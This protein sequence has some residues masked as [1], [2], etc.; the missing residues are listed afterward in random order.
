MINHTAFRSRAISGKLLASRPSNPVGNQNR[1]SKIEIVP[2]WSPPKF[3][4]TYQ[5]ACSSLQTLTVCAELADTLSVRTANGLPFL[6]PIKPVRRQISFER[7]A[8]RQF[9]LF[10]ASVLIALLSACGASNNMPG[11]TN[12]GQPPPTDTVS[13]KVQLNGAPLA[14]V[15]VTE[16][17]TNNNTVVATTTTDS[18]G[19]Y[20]FSGLST[21]GNSPALYQFWATKSGY[22]FYPSV[23]SGAEVV[24]FDH[25][26]NMQGSTSFGI[27]IFFTVI[28]FTSLPNASLSGAD[29]NAYDGGNP[30]VTLPRTGQTTSYA[31]GDDAA[32]Q[33]G[34]AWPAQRFTDNHDGT[35]TDGLTGLVWLKNA[36]CFTPTVWSNAITQVNQL[37]GGACGLTDQS[38]AGQW[39]M[40]NI[41]ELESIVDVSASNPALTPGSPFTNVSNAIYWSSTTYFGGEEG[42]PD[43]WT[44][45]FS[46]G[47]YMNDDVVNQKATSNNAVWAVKG[48]GGGTIK[49]QSTGAYVPFATG[50]DG[51]IQ[52]GVPPTFQRWADNDDG[53]VTD[54]VTGLIWLKQA[55]CINQP[56]SAAIAAVNSLASG[57]CG[58]TDG[59]AAGSWRMPNRNEMQSL[60]DRAENNLGAFFDQNYFNLDG[61]LFQAPIF[62]SFAENQ[63]YWTSSTDAADPSEAWTVFSCDFGV[64]DIPK[65]DSAYTLA[66]R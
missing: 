7:N 35:V 52:A 20:S 23:G 51:A 66:V 58:L 8:M 21:S 27:A 40:P 65:F 19:A 11:L 61:T 34:A 63:Y 18:N 25:T 45:R 54:T 62:T 64:Y 37:A 59:S 57:Q 33:K 6:F 3:H 43:A 56:W 38:T 28:Q 2:R 5:S 17:L 1:L 9:R 10:L 15:T 16:W 50:D 24:R 36:G 53:T 31:A 44:I 30:L 29:F 55:N 41:N 14:G 47:R 26:G 42:S 4:A 46:D 32:L 60:S 22:G 39:R 48:S 49:L 13:G 12:P